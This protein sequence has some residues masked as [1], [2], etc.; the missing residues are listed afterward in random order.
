MKEEIRKMENEWR[1]SETRCKSLIDELQSQSNIA[2]DD[3]PVRQ[4]PKDDKDNTIN[5][6]DVGEC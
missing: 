4:E 5:I 3:P 2:N 6:L 1:E